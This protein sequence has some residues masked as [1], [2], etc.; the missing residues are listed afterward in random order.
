MYLE[1]YNMNYCLNVLIVL[2]YC[3]NV[4][5]NF[6][7]KFKFE[8]LI[9]IFGLYSNISPQNTGVQQRSCQNPAIQ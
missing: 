7:L 8:F 2:N 4:L 1:I 3:L 5:R 9:F 6:Y